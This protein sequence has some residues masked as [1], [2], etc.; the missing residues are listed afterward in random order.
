MMPFEPVTDGLRLPAPE[1]GV[2]LLVGSNREEYRLF[3]VPTER[4]DVLS[5]RKLRATAAAYG[6]DPD[7]AFRSTA[8]PG[9]MRCPERSSTRWRRTGSTGF[10]R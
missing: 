5:E 7:K 2:E 6:L 1:C 10:R 8:R 3:L 9:R 4:L